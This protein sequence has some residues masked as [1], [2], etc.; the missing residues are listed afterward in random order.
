MG[1]LI[2]MK[3]GSDRSYG[4]PIYGDTRFQHLT[5]KRN[6]YSGEKYDIL[7][8]QFYN[9]EMGEG[10][11][12]INYTESYIGDG[13]IVGAKST[14]FQILV[15]SRMT[16]AFHHYQ[17]KATSRRWMMLCHMDVRASR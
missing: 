14:S 6:D 13:T 9:L 4:L 1:E 8:C 17:Q 11:Q 12:M 2:Q 5:F 16:T 15:V 7:Y 10:I 3:G